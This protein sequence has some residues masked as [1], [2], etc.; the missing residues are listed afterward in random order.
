MGQPS[1]KVVGDGPSD[2]AA[3]IPSDSATKVQSSSRAFRNPISPLRRS[4]RRLS[5]QAQAAHARASEWSATLSSAFGLR[6]M[7]MVVAQYGFNQGIGNKLVQTAQNYYLLEGLGLSSER[8]GLI[9]AAAVIP[10]QLKS[11]FGLI[12][13][14]FPIAGYRRAPY[15]I[16]GG[17]AG[18]VASL[19]LA[20]LPV[21]QMTVPL[22]AALFILYNVNVAMSD[23]M[24]DATIAER[25]REQPSLAADLQVLSWGSQGLLGI[26][27]GL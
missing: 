13:D 19:L 27:A 18:T 17:A 14:A 22:T 16:F 23:V 26:P 4:A 9:Q 25:S 11:L 2:S 12:S 15:I 20:L 7:S 5:V 10:W 1:S 8:A 3:K 6:Y 24:I 21:R